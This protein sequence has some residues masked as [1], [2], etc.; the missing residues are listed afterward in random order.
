[1]S[2]PAPARIALRILFARHGESTANR[3]RV[4]ANRDSA[5]PLTELG[6]AQ[7]AA[8]ADVARPEHVQRILTSP[9][10]RA[11]ETAEIVGRAL[12]VPVEAADALREFDCGEYEG[13]SDAAAWQAHAAA[14]RDW[15]E[16]DRPDSRLPGGESLTDMRARFE[17]LLRMV[18]RDLL[19]ARRDPGDADPRAILLVSHGG[20]LRCVLPPLL[21]G[22]D[23]A[24]A[25]SRYLGNAELI[26]ADIQPDGTLSG[27]A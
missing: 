1:M 10:R 5:H 26:G 16:L 25:R 7:A 13:R 23:G 14:V 20:L 27:R 12:G 6:R 2:I 15:L 19:E 4:I 18:I 21:D 11:V 3:L 22:I 24:L 8:L 9:I 17:P